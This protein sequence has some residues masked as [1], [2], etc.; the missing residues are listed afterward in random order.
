M[1]MRAKPTGGQG[2]LP[3]GERVTV[4]WVEGLSAQ[5]WFFL[6]LFRP[7]SLIEVSGLG[8]G[9]IPILAALLFYPTLLALWVDKYIVRRG[10]R[11]MSPRTPL[12]S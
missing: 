9:G 4:V 12:S 7:E 6:A 8:I 10:R 2:D 3:G 11:V 1:D 5:A